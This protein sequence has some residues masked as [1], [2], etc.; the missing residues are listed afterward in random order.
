MENLMT[1][2]HGKK[3]AARALKNANPALTYPAARRLVHGQPRTT[4]QPIYNP[5]DFD[6]IDRVL[7][8]TMI[9]SEDDLIGQK[10]T[11]I[12]DG[13]GF[14]VELDDALAEITIDHVVMFRDWTAN[15]DVHE[16]YEGGGQVGEC[17]IEAVLEYSATISRQDF[18]AASPPVPWSVS[19]PN[20]SPTHILVTG[21]LAAELSYHFEYGGSGSV[22]HFVF[23]GLSFIDSV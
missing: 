22:E 19:D 13:N 1:K 10:L 18:A 6:S 23:H 4:S 14:Y 2:N 11:N 8:A 21:N 5:S 12:A 20:W 15:H 16:V 17:Q 7:K 3:K 9:G